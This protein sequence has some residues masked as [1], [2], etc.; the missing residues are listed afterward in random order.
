MLQK[1]VVGKY[2]ALRQA[3]VRVVVRIVV[4]VGARASARDNIGVWP[5]HYWSILSLP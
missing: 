4:G 5:I 2:Q 3:E 1:G